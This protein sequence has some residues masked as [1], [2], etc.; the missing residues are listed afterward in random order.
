MTPTLDS[1]DVFFALFVFACP[2]QN[3]AND[4][5]H[6]HG[7]EFAFTKSHSKS[8]PQAS[9]SCPLTLYVNVR[10]L[11]LS[12]SDGGDLNRH[13]FP[14]IKQVDRRIQRR[15]GRRRA[16]P[17]RAGCRCKH[18]DELF[19]CRQRQPSL[20]SDATNK[21]QRRRRRPTNERGRRQ[22][23]FPPKNPLVAA[24]GKIPARLPP[25]QNSPLYPTPKKKKKKTSKN[26]NPRVKMYVCL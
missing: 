10:S 13:L 6:R 23:L 26:P 7:G 17:P 19:D 15:G 1:I 14:Q 8:T 20:S 5:H 4:Q 25:P 21:R 22:S 3:R 24:V 18:W 12:C 11:S 9:I 16:R 2:C